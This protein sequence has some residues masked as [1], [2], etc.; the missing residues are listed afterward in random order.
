MFAGA[1]AEPLAVLAQAAFSAT[2]NVRALPSS[3]AAIVGNL[4][5][6]PRPVAVH[7]LLCVAVLESVHLPLLA[8]GAEQVKQEIEDV[9]Q[10]IAVPQVLF[11]L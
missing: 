2:A 5:P 1:A 11:V 9:P 8:A 4:P 10:F 7:V 3:S 6:A